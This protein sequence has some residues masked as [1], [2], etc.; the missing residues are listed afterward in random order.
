MKRRFLLLTAVIIAL[1][2]PGT[3]A[4]LASGRS[5]QMM[6]G[7]MAPVTGRKAEVNF[8]SLLNNSGR[9]YQSWVR[10]GRNYLNRREFEQAIWALRKAIELRPAAEEARFLL[11]Y[12][13]EQRGLEG[14]PGDMTDWDALAAREYISAIEL[15]D[16]LPSRFNLAVLHRRHGR[17]EDARRHLEHI[18]LIKDSGA[19][20][21]KASSELN[22]L[23][24]QDVRPR[25]ISSKVRDITS[26]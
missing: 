14:L 16:H 7:A 18:L 9:E 23:F 10:D 6:H 13:Y 26:P 4:Y 12:T 2:L 20:G 22:A 11:G 15:A 24:H 21:R 19:L 8:Y 3:K 17:F 1:F 25:S 5:N